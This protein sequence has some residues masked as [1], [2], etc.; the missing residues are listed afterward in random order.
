MN[1]D[2]VILRYLYKE[3]FRVSTQ[4]LQETR[5]DKHNSKITIIVRL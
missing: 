5:L 1:R 4:E 3:G 2:D